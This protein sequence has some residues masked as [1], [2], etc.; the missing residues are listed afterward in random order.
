MGLP[1]LWNL[2]KASGS[3]KACSRRALTSQI[4]KFDNRRPVTIRIDK[5]IPIGFRV[6]KVQEHRMRTLV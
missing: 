5:S 2:A 3:L 1:T 4:G 6:R